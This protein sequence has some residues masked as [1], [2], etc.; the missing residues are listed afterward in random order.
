VELREV[1]ELVE[2]LEMR[3][4]RLRALYD[5]YFMGLE[6]MEPGVPRKDVDRRIYQLRKEQ[7]RNTGLRFRFNMIIQRYN[8]Y[9]TFWARVCRQIEDGTYKRHMLRAKVRFGIDLRKEQP[10]NEV[11]EEYDVEFP[12]DGDEVDDQ[13]ERGLGERP[14]MLDGDLVIPVDAIELDYD[15]DEPPQPPLSIEFDEPFG[16]LRHTPLPPSQ[17]P[18]RQSV[19]PPSAPRSARGP[20]WRKRAGAGPA[21]IAGLPA[22]LPPAA[23]PK[24]RTPPPALGVQTPVPVA[25]PRPVSTPRAP[26]VPVP[27]PRPQPAPPPAAPA[28]PPGDLPEERVRQLYAQY[29]D[30]KRKRNESTAAITYDGLAKSLR[31]SS[32]KLRAQHGRTVD[33]E[34]AVKD[35]KTVIRPVVK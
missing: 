18:E 25:P 13:L 17:A 26:S 32:A 30:T 31:D 12:F 24:P 20:V 6:K 35:G 16:A 10:T 29:V 2:E 23:P 14:G 9:Q 27:V 34:V 11:N 8:T 1:Q 22:E 28:G 7:I 4:D 15:T 19:P 5:Q 3:L 21:G 33:F